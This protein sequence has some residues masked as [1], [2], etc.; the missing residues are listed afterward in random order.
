MLNDVDIYWFSGTGNTLRV[1]RAMEE[2]F[3]TAGLNVWT[4]R[5]EDSD[6]RA[7]DPSHTLGIA[8]TVACQGTYPP[9]WDFVEQLPAVEGTEVF[10]VDTLAK[11]SGGI[12]G[13]MR[14][15][16]TD[17]GYRPIGAREIR[18]PNNFLQKSLDP[19]KNRQVL[20]AGLAEA[21][22]FAGE[23]IED[24][25]QWAGN[26]GWQR[27][28]NWTARWKLTWKFAR[29]IS[30]I[31]IASDRCTQCGLCAELCPVGNIERTS[32]GPTLGP[33]CI[34]CQRCFAFC[35]TGAVCVGKP[36]K[37]APYRAVSVGDIRG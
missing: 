6:P 8:A 32:A 31:R 13:P 23:L 18:M 5:I 33:C 14:D 26:S 11:I 19:R 2:V 9:V 30:P 36:G 15:V 29:R 27:F 28:V 25:A 35:P 1:V 17:K 4:G 7:I 12:V 20:E 37:Y 3:R 34:A 22:T 16:L 21:R 10:L 24:R